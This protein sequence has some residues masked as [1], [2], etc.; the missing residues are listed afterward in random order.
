MIAFLF[1]ILAALPMPGT[2]FQ[3]LPEGAGKAEVEAACYACHSADI[4]VQQR[5]TP[6]QWTATVDKMIR[7]GVEAKEPE[8]QR[9]IDY[10]SKHFGPDNRFTPI[11]TAPVK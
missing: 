2:R 6:K 7:W 5:L 8:R 10:L 4:V 9:M 1:L 3:Q 11:A